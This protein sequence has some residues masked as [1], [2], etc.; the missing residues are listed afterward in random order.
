MK[1]PKFW[2]K[3][4]TIYKYILLPLSYIWLLG[5]FLN[6]ITKKPIRF[7]VPVICV[8]NLI[9]GGGG[10]TPLTILIAT[11]FKKKG[12]IYTLLKNNINAVIRKKYY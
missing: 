6:K 1:T 11:F 10:K 12:L 3:S 2:Y 5:S 7:N 4:K 8:G 9:A